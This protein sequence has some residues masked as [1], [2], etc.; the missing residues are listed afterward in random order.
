MN[1]GAGVLLAE[2]AEFLFAT[3]FS[4]QGSLQHLPG[5][6]PHLPS[7]QTRPPLLSSSEFP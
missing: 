4:P 7:G 3:T 5:T 6:T 2:I 1:T